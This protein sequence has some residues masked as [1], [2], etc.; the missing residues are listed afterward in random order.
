MFKLSICQRYHTAPDALVEMG[1][2][3]RKRHRLLPLPSIQLQRIN[4][5]LYGEPR[6]VQVAKELIKNFVTLSCPPVKYLDSLFGQKKTHI[7]P[8]AAC[9]LVIPPTWLCVC[10]ATERQRRFYDLPRSR[11]L[12]ETFALPLCRRDV[13]F[14]TCER[15]ERGVWGWNRGTEQQENRGGGWGQRN[16]G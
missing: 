15:R 1:S 3:C 10:T 7:R 13:M 12:P 2:R 6:G 16:G 14:S 4:Y 5:A 11:R 9:A 8:K